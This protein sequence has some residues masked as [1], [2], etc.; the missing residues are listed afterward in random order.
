M[1]KKTLIQNS[2]VI[3][4][5]H[6]PNSEHWVAAGSIELRR[7]IAKT[8]TMHPIQN[9][10]LPPDRRGDVTYYNP[11]TKEKLVNGRRTF[12]VRGVAGGDRISYTG[13]VSSSTASLQL[14]KVL[15]HSVVS[16]NGDCISVISKAFF[17]SAPSPVLSTYAYQ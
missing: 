9:H 12:C 3:F 11:I 13:V 6:G 14:V 16:D 4:K 17:F 8:R 1:F 7:F 2:S 5:S 15:L 10:A